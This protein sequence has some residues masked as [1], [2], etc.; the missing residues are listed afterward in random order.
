MLAGGRVT[1]AHDVTSSVGYEPIPSSVLV[2]PCQKIQYSECKCTNSATIKSKLMT[3]DADCVD[4]DMY[5]EYRG[6][7]RPKF[8]V[9]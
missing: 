8:S 3:G 6:D 1:C 7:R 9:V 4:D 2:T 5:G